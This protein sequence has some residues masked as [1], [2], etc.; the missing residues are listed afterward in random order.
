MLNIKLQK[1]IEIQ[2]IDAVERYQIEVNETRLKVLK[3]IH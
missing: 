1:D 3:K 2:L